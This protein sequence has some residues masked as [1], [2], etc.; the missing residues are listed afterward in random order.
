VYTCAPKTHRVR[1][2]GREATVS[3][4]SVSSV[5]TTRLLMPNVR[6]P[7]LRLFPK[8]HHALAH[9]P[10]STENRQSTTRPK[11]PIKDR[12]KIRAVLPKY[13]DLR[14]ARVIRSVRSYGRGDQTRRRLQERWQLFKHKKSIG[15]MLSEKH[16]IYINRAPYKSYSVRFMQFWFVLDV[17]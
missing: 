3:V 1:F 8:A 16:F 13:S 4:R 17:H 11:V 6:M 15:V 2:K 7:F 10:L 5:Y 12:A 9:M 14:A